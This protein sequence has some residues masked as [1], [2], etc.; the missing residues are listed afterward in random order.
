MKILLYI[1]KSVPPMRNC[2]RHPNIFNILSSRTDYFK[3]YFSFP[4]LLNAINLTVT[5][6]ILVLKIIS[7]MLYW[8]SLSLLLMLLTRLHVGFSQF[9]EHKFRHDFNQT[10]NLLCFFTI[11]T[12]NI[13]HYFPSCNFY[14]ENWATLMNNF[15]DNNFIRQFLY[16]NDL[17]WNNKNQSILMCTLR[18]IKNSQKFSE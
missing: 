12:E 15:N 3:N 11:E 4:L 14:N 1:Y 17:F 6:K 18:L 9:Q 13:T 2:W 8:N 10:L 16:G 5:S 7:L